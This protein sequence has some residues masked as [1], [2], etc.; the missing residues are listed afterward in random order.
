MT[1]D[2]RHAVDRPTV[3]CAHGIPYAGE[4][5]RNEPDFYD[6]V[7]CLAPREDSDPTARTVERSVERSILT[8][9][10]YPE[11][12]PGDGF[13]YTVSLL[14]AIEQYREEFR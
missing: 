7:G 11:E 6:L 4:D 5:R 14:A 12:V 13:N 9:L 1:W 8:T 2:A 10:P 3:T